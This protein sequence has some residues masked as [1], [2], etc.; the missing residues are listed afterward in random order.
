MG[1]ARLGRH[2]YERYSAAVARGLLGCR[3][4]RV[5]DGKR[6]SGIIVE[7]EAYT[8]LRD[9]ASHAYRGRTARNEVMFGP[10]GHAYVYF[11]MGMHH[12]LNVTTEGEGTPAAVLIRAMEPV[13][14]VK[15]MMKERTSYDVKR[16]AAGPGNLAKALGIDVRLNG[17]D[18]VLSRRLFVEN[19]K[20]VGKVAVSSRV[21]ISA[22]RSFKWRYFLAGNPFVSRGKPSVPAQNP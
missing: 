3:L 16:L 18:M 1:L 7:T 21:G 8:G 14:G 2:F 4:V 20:R 15:R 22:G 19:V 10:A 5:L 6:L 17:E 11:T 9:P 13:E 12:C